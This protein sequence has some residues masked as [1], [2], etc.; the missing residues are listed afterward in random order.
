MLNILPQASLFKDG[1]HQ[2]VFEWCLRFTF[3]P[4]AFQDFGN[5]PQRLFLSKEISFKFGKT[6]ESKSNK[7]T[8]C[9]FVILS[10]LIVSIV[11]ERKFGMDK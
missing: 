1:G 4:F 9:P 5:G 2:S 3:T 10:N 8:P 7:A 6:F 11:G